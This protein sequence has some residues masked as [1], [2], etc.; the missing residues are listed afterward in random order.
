M[1]KARRSAGATDVLALWY[2]VKFRFVRLT[3]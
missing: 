1:T 3:R 2:V